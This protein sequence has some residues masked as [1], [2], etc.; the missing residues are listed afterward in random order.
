MS[1]EA[2]D[3]M[4]AEWEERLRRVDESLLALEAEPTYQMLAP[5]PGPASSQAARVRLEGET[6]RVVEPALEALTELFEQ[7]GRLTEVLDRAKEVR[8]SMSGL[9]FWANDEKER[10]IQALLHG[11]SIE[12]PPQTTPLARRALLDPGAHDVR[13]VPE[14]LLGAMA[15]AFE[16]ARDAVVS[17]QHAWERLEPSMAAVAQRVSDARAA[18]ESLGVEPGVH[19]ELAAVE[20]D[21]ESVRVRVARDPLGTSADVEARLVPRVESVTSRL[22]DLVALRDRVNDGTARARAE[23]DELRHT[24]ARALDAVTR[25]PHEI[26]GAIAP[27]APVDDGLVEGL[28]PWLDKIEDAARAG[29]WPTAEVG[30]AKWRE[31]AGAYRSND[32]K[33]AGAF[34]KVIGRREELAGRLSARR[35]QAAA[36][37]AR[38]VVIETVAEQA[39]REAERL[40]VERPTHLARATEAVEKY[41]RLVRVRVT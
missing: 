29:R 19:D 25:L 18:A 15:A 41:E 32:G 5:R 23:L 20:R 30:L 8:A 35:A 9:A 7:R 22:A 3:R 6:K 34:E 28:A 39:A 38:G 2:V 27:G 31:A 14:Q 24:H 40:L 10:E 11:P 26:H 17:V 12:L 37:A 13:V 4:L 36:L 21:L 33:I 1:V 16:R